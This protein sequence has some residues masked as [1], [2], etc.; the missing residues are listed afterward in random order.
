MKKNRFF[1]SLIIGICCL[2]FFSC[3]NELDVPP[4]LEY[5]GSSNRTIAQ[6]LSLHTV[7]G[8]YTL[9]EDT[10]VIQ[11][12]VVSSDQ[13]GNCYK[14]LMIQDETGG[15]EILINNSSLYSKYPIGQKV[16]VKCQ[17]LVL[18]DYNGLMQLSCVYNNATERIPTLRESEFI[19]R[20]GL[21]GKEPTPKAIANLSD[22]TEKD[23]NTL[24]RIENCSFITPGVPFVQPGENNSNRDV[25]AHGATI[26]MRTSSYATFATQ[27]LGEGKFA[28]KGLLTRFGSTKQIIIRSLQDI[29]FIAQPAILYEANMHQDP[30]NAG[31]TKFNIAGLSNWNYLSVES[32]KG[33]AINV[34]SGVSNDDFLISPVLPT[35]GTKNVKL[36]LTHRVPGN[37]G[38]ST[39]MK[40]YYS[41]ANPSSSFNISDWTEILTND[42]DFPSNFEEKI[43]TISDNITS[44]PNF[45]IALRYNDNRGSQWYISAFSIQGFPIA[46]E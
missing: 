45:R 39:N 2:T 16:F 19:F 6:L 18:S 11:G 4:V 35:S 26:V 36:Y 1:L 25:D 34:S 30:F 14:Y 43:F 32:F 5:E 9:I 37:M 28:I 40:L 3:K 13:E 27:L 17:G 20:S 7:G 21:P 24:V 10:L 22:I 12:T 23:Y 15:I 31:W 46:I 42:T 33:F 41:T 44:S 38:N 8:P 29:E